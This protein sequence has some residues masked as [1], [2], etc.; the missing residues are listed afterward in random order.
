MIRGSTPTLSFKIPFDVSVFDRGFVTFKQMADDGT[1]L[2][3]L[4]KALSD[5]ETSGNKINVTLSQ[6]ETLSFFPDIPLLIQ[7]RLVDNLEQA[8]VSDI[9]TEPVFDVLKDGII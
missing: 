7:I 5:C 9:M 6:A 8:P 1:V 4:D 3:Y 2:S